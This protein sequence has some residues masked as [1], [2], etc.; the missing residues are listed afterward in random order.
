MINHKFVSLVIL[1]S[2]IIFSIGCIE[3]FDKEKF[4]NIDNE[5]LSF[6]VVSDTHFGSG[7]S[8][9]QDKKFNKLLD[10]IDKIS[11]DFAVITGD[12]TTADEYGWKTSSKKYI[13]FRNFVNIPIF[14]LPG[15]HDAVNRYLKEWIDTT[16]K[17]IYYSFDWRGIHFINLADENED[18]PGTISNE[19]IF[20][21]K[22]EIKNNSNKTIIVFSH[23]PLPYT[24]K[25]SYQPEN[26]VDVLERS[27]EIIGILNTTNAVKLWFSGHSHLDSSF[28]PS[29]KENYGVTHINIGA[30]L[31]TILLGT[32]EIRIVEIQKNNISI[33]TYDVNKSL[34]YNDSYIINT[35]TSLGDNEL[36]G[37]IDGSYSL[38]KES[39][40]LYER[41]YLATY[42]FDNDKGNISSQWRLNK[43]GDDNSTLEI[44]SDNAKRGKYAG[45]YAVKITKYNERGFSSFRTQYTNITPGKMYILSAWYKSDKKISDKKIPN[46]IGISLEWIDKNNKTI[47][48][49][50]TML[51]SK[52]GWNRIDSTPSIAPSGATKV[53]LGLNVFNSSSVYWDLIRFSYFDYMK[54]EYFIVRTCEDEYQTIKYCN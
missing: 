50:K 29:I 22:N 16:N 38:G 26:K 52:I 41:I 36:K 31:D 7:I 21:F 28:K 6:I 42:S 46:S 39:N 51:N 40:L 9:I 1:C 54:D 20:W 44:I 14:E 49:S 10:S 17:P 25:G 4:N 34:L 32:F 18:W 15:N 33:R 8:D 11:P 30:A 24:V 23:Q 37:D 47:S 12:L 13:D 3:K 43:I 35:N 53:E 48:Q 19:Q 2:L 27:D 5:S 45:K